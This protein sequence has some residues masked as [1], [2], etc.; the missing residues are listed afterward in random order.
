MTVI[1]CGNSCDVQKDISADRLVPLTVP[2][3]TFCGVWHLQK[4]TESNFPK[5]ELLLQFT[6]E[7]M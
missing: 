5:S 2:G 7:V 6:P 3:Q 4:A 1:K